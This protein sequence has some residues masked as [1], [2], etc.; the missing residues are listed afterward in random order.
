MQV[1]SGDVLLAIISALVGAALSYIIGL[2]H[3]QRRFRQELSSNNNIVVSG[4]DWHAA[5]QASVDS[6]E[7]LNTEHLVINQKGATL[8]MWNKEKSPENPKGG[9]LW[10]GQ[11]QFF[12]GRDV[13]GWYFPKKTENNASKGI[14]FLNYNSS[15][16]IFIGKW[17]GASYDGPLSTGFVVIS[18]ERTASLQILRHILANHPSKVC[19][20]SEVI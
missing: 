14:M 18:K 20:I 17:V 15:Q 7:L 12:H 5:W 11:L 9:Y 16:K 3:E 19:I 6:H 4:D 2:L 13:M 10:E 1:T 8:R